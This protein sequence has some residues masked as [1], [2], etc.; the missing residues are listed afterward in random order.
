VSG[1]NALARDLEG[2]A[3]TRRPAHVRSDQY[4]RSAHA[5]RADGLDEHGEA[6]PPYEP[7]NEV[8]AGARQVS[9]AEVAIPLRT[10]ARE[11]RDRIRPPGYSVTTG[12]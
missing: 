9:G 2:W 12:V 5:M 7:K 4:Q 6:P 3:G 8:T 10:H 11:E 1:Q